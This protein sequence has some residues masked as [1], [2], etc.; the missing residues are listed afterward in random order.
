MSWRAAVFTLE[1]ASIRDS[2]SGDPEMMTI[3]PGQTKPGGPI[4]ADSATAL[5]GA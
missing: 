2:T 4:V 1:G 5:G 3:F